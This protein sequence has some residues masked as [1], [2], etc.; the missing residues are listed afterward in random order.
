MIGID[1]SKATLQCALCDPKT[2]EVIWNI[3]TPNSP[4]GVNALLKKTSPDTSWVIEPTGRYSLSVARQAQ[5]AGR[6]VLLAPP[7]KAKAYLN[8]LQSR[9]KTDKLDA[10][11]LAQ[12]GLSRPLR[13]Y[14]IKEA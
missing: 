3:S 14:P 7:C 1:T 8:S 5:E 10:K 6:E 11:G 2:R 9:A 4:E 12:F 13:P